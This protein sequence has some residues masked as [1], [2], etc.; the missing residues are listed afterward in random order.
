[1]I[2]GYPEI[3]PSAKV[4]PPWAASPYVGI[5]HPVAVSSSVRKAAPLAFL[6]PA[7]PSLR[8]RA[9]V[10]VVE[11]MSS[12]QTCTVWRQHRASPQGHRAFRYLG[13]LR[14][15]GRKHRPDQS[16]FSSRKSVVPKGRG[17]RS[18]RAPGDPPTPPRPSGRPYSLP[19]ERHKGRVIPIF[20][21]GPLELGTCRG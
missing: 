9:P 8:L 12:L 5:T 15:R 17:A 14:P 1:M 3:G 16:A 21:V 19:G 2:W 20:G 18:G 13:P 6:A 4:C 11:A 10:S 7:I